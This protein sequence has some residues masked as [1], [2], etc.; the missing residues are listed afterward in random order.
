MSNDQRYL[1]IALLIRILDLI[2]ER[3]RIHSVR[4]YRHGFREKSW[5]TVFSLFL[6]SSFRQMSSAKNQPPLKTSKLIIIQQKKLKMYRQRRKYL[7]LNFQI[8]A[9][10]ANVQVINLSIK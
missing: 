5:I 2:Q 10:Y 6:F 1:I 7:R 3:S 9:P 4:F 8:C